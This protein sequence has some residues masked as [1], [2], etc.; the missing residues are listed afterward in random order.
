MGDEDDAYVGDDPA[1][2]GTYHG[3]LGVTDAWDSN[4]AGNIPLSGA[5]TNM[6]DGAVDGDIKALTM[7]VAEFGGNAVAFAGD[8]VNWL[9]SAGLAFLIDV[10]QPL[11]D[12]LSLVTGNYERMG[13]FTGRWNR[14][15]AALVPLGE[16]VRQAAADGL[17][18]WE[19][20]DADAAKARL[21]EFGEA[22]EASGGEAVKVSSLLNI[23]A[24]LMSAA[25]QIIIGLIAQFVEWLII[26]WTAALA[27]AGVT[28]GGSTAGAATVT[29]LHATTNCSRAVRI[30]DRVVEFLNRIGRVLREVLPGFV[31]DNVAKNYRAISA[32]KTPDVGDMGKA[33]GRWLKDWKNYMP[34]AGTVGAA[35]VND[36]GTP[37]SGMSGEDIENGLDPGR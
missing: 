27:A 35:G 34:M 14:I 19:G 3:N 6:Y 32:L 8:P 31:K 12:A 11:E 24:S 16:A 28:F 37:G 4:Y 22:I 17:I 26:T 21:E 36:I 18:G 2:D 7:G 9:L 10:I 1:A 13:E 20:K 30:I 23:L 33:L 29:T 5:A 25:Q 15:G